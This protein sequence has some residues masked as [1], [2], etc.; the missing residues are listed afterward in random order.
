MQ[1]N[2]N[3]ILVLALFV[4]V[5]HAFLP[6]QLSLQWLCGSSCTWPHDVWLHIAGTNEPKIAQQAKE[7]A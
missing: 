7:G 1:V 6:S 4:K 2:Q 3:H 5:L